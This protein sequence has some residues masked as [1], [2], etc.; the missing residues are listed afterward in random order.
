MVNFK[1]VFVAMSTPI[2]A[3]GEPDV[4]AIGRLVLRVM[5]GGVAGVCPLGSTGEGSALTHVQ[6]L[7]VL[8]AVGEA[9]ARRV[10]VVPAI[11][12]PSARLAQEELLVYAAHGASAALVCPP[13]YFPLS[14]DEVR[15][16]YEDLADRSPIP[17][18]VY[19]IP[20]LARN[21]ASAAVLAVLSDHGNIVGL[22]DS[23]RDLQYLQ[24]VLA[25]VSEAGNRER[26]SVLTGSD[27]LLFPS[28]LLGADG[29][30]GAAANLVAGITVAL[31]DAVVAGEFRE[32]GGLQARLTAIVRACRVGGTGIGWKAALGL[33]GVCGPDPVAPRLALTTAQTEQLRAA[34]VSLGV[35]SRHSA[36]AQ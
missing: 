11:L 22:K 18:L 10:P 15:G 1:G 25:A 21:M 29:I 8:D 36:E 26:F 31:Y 28:L 4:A 27:N 17:I 13:L 19:S 3:S 34:L 33:A 32:A 6:R 14:Q 9:T 16:F 24:E 2:E 30:I 12:S 23:T 35:I 5:S 20:S 7:A